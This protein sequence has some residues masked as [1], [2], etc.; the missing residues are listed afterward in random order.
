MEAPRGTAYGLGMRR[1]ALL[2]LTLF[3]SGAL[4]AHPEWKEANC[5]GVIDESGQLTL[6]AP[7]WNEADTQSLARSLAASG[8]QLQSADG[9]FTLGRRAEGGG[10]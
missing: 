8:W 1:F 4:S 10:P 7:G 3:C 5:L 2:C 9:L 6:A